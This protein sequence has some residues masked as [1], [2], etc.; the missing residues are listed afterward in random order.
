MKKLNE[1]DLLSK[2]LATSSK[3]SEAYRN[4]HNYSLNN[5]I[6]A[7]C[8]MDEISPIST[9]KNWQK[10][11]RQVKKGAKAI[12]LCMPKITVTNKDTE[13]EK[14]FTRFIFVKRWF[15]MNDT[16]GEEIPE[17]KTPV[18]SFEKVLNHFQIKEVTFAQINGN[19]LGY[20]N[21]NR[22][23]AINPLNPIKAKTRF[24][25]IAHIL[26]GHLRQG[27]ISDND[28][29]EKNIM[30]VEAELTAFIC[31]SSLGLD[32]SEECKGYIE[33]W[34]DGEEIPDSSIKKCFKTAEEILNIGTLENGGAK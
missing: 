6:L 15:S 11:G 22:E 24:H 32:G 5:R 21:T 18:F 34:L 3:L 2:L 13:D 7:M 19:I 25:E 12:E 20:A 27:L 28:T 31:V 33:S 9:Y 30:E 16:E 23:I 14:T 1:Q 4:F 17:Q 29:I 10:L 8:Q 26:L